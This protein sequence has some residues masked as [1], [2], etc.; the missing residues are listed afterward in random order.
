MGRQGELN[1]S[2][3]DTSPVLLQIKLTIVTADLLCGIIPSVFEEM[4]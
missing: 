1:I 4:L 3:N 2:G